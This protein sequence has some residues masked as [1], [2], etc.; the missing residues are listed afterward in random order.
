[1]GVYGEMGNGVYMLGSIW[2]SNHIPINQTQVVT[3]NGTITFVVGI[4]EYTAWLE[5]KSNIISIIITSSVARSLAYDD[6]IYRTLDFYLRLIPLAIFLLL[7]FPTH[8]WISARSV[9]SLH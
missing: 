3:R 6:L 5:T 9:P 2:R 1:M 4:L 7:F 8:P